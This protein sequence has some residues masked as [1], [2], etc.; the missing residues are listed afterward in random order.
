[1]WIIYCTKETKA[2][3][4]Q[5]EDPSSIRD[6]NTIPFSTSTIDHT[7]SL[8][9][10]LSLLTS[11]VKKTEYEPGSSDIGDVKEM[12]SLS[13]IESTGN[14][15]WLQEETQDNRAFKT[16]LWQENPKEWSPMPGRC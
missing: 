4:W 10:S 5:S 14:L 11:I 8:S 7:Q 1:M 16:L 6:P 15:R 13:I 2:I 9:L 3:D 12:T